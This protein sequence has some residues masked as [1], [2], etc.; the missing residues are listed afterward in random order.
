MK[1]SNKKLSLNQIKVESFI[2]N[3][4]N[5]ENKTIVGATGVIDTPLQKPSDFLPVLC[6]YGFEIRSDVPASFIDGRCGEG[7]GSHH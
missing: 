5:G 7:N 1:T 6:L 4:D 3:M 2:T